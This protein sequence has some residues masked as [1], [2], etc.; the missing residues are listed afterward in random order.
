MITEM[1]EIEFEKKTG[2]K[3][4]DAALTV[5]SPF[6]LPKEEDR[7]LTIGTVKFDKTIDLSFI[8]AG[9][10]PRIMITGTIG[11][12]DKGPEKATIQFRD[13]KIGFH[14]PNNIPVLKDLLLNNDWL[15]KDES[16]A[17]INPD[18]IEA[19]DVHILHQG[20]KHTGKTEISS[21]VSLTGMGSATGTR[22]VEIRKHNLVIRPQLVFIPGKGGERDLSVILNQSTGPVDVRAHDNTRYH[23]INSP[24]DPKDSAPMIIRKALADAAYTKFLEVFNKTSKDKFGVSPGLTLIKKIDVKK[25]KLTAQE[26]GF[27]MVWASHNGTPTDNV[28]LVF[29]GLILDSIQLEPRT[30]SKGTTSHILTEALG[31]AVPENAPLVLSTDDNGW[32]SDKGRILLNEVTFTLLDNGPKVS[33]GA[34]GATLT[35]VT[36]TFLILPSLTGAFSGTGPAAP[37]FAAVVSHGMS[38]VIREGSKEIVTNLVTFESPNKSIATVTNAAFSLTKGVARAGDVQSHESGFTGIKGTLDLGW[39]G[40]ASDTVVTWILPDLEKVDIEAPG[41]KPGEHKAPILLDTHM[42]PTSGRLQK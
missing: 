39:L 23:W 25:G 42:P 21:T 29:V 36:R 15:I 22:P 33:L 4:I 38:Y 30:I 28:T 35:E 14:V 1:S 9:L 26:P 19:F 32:L 31:L 16:I 11:L 12:A 34:I 27:Q 41:D 7:T 10:N 18:N 5:L 37:F 20:P 2:V 17:R 6:L 8:S 40:K 13:F 3:L 24:S